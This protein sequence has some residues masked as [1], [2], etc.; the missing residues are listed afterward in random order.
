LSKAGSAEPFFR[1]KS[2][3]KTIERLSSARNLT[4]FVGAGVGTEIG[5][6]DWPQLVR[7]LLSDA[8]AGPKARAWARPLSTENR[9]T[10]DR[11][12]ERESLL[13]AAT[14]AKARLGRR[15]KDS[16]RRALYD[17]RW[18]DR[19][20]HVP[21]HDAAHG[22]LVSTTAE[23]VAAVYKA[24]ATT[25]DQQW[26]CDIV[27]T[28]YDLSLEQALS[29]VGI[30]AE[31]WLEDGGPADDSGIEHVVRHLH[32]Y[33]TETE[34]SEKLVLTEA[35]Y[36]EAGADKLSWQESY[37]RRRLRES[38]VVFVG[39]S[40]SDP[41]ILSV[42][43]RYAS[44]KRRAVALLAEKRPNLQSPD[45]PAPPDPTQAAYEDLA[46][47][48]WETAGL[49]VLRADYLAQPRQFLW[50]VA[51]HKENPGALRYGKRLD[52]WYRKVSDGVPLALTSVDTFGEAQD[53][54]CELAGGWLDDVRELVREAGHPSIDDESLAIHLWSR[55][56]L[57][58]VTGNRKAT[59]LCAMAMV[60][61]SDRA[62]RWPQA[63]DTRRI[64]Q[65]TRRAAIEAFCDRRVLE[66]HHDGS[67]QWNYVL[68]IPV[69]LT[70]PGHARL[71]VGTITLESTAPA[72]STELGR[73]T[74]KERQDVVEYLRGVG[75]ACLSAT[76]GKP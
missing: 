44:S 71:P 1:R 22:H 40:L 45:V 21:A 35:D 5:L 33:L 19:T 4:V 32:G 76:P 60:V 70:G 29:R 34:A 52:A 42:L 15:F 64:M 59:G 10:V 51:M 30:D 26:S 9:E 18:R 68:A 37:L 55:S 46:L 66:C 23:A 72:E 56:T 6:P 24:F 47:A 63:V 2:V 13:S 36:H 16:L 67:Y 11:L 61:C 12:L 57:P 14:I 27:T 58:L 28:N 48:R 20:L 39:T 17:Q 74:I 25:A 38:T 65:P 43:F 54:L 50:E 75:E 62:W 41:D 7:R 3:K 69:V 31:P 53:E 8:V 73:L 49:D